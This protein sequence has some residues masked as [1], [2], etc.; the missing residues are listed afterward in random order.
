MLLA[1]ELNNFVVC[2]LSKQNSE[3]STH[4]RNRY[5]VN[6]CTPC[7]DHHKNMLILQ[8]KGHLNSV[9]VESEIHQSS[10][11]NLTQFTYVTIRTNTKVLHYPY[12]HC[13]GYIVFTVHLLSPSHSCQVT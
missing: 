5:V 12:M 7:P 4:H 8:V 6:Y 10:Y 1:V 3:T 13:H 9:E 11:T 2:C